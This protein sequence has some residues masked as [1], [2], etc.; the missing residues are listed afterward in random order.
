MGKPKL[1][2]KCGWSWGGIRSLGIY[3]SNTA[4]F[5]GTERTVNQPSRNVIAVIRLLCMY[6]ERSVRILAELAGKRE[7]KETDSGRGGEAGERNGRHRER[8]TPQ[9]AV[10]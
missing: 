1:P 9:R 4:A 3:R 5:R 6:L 2:L 8:L 10:M 7:K